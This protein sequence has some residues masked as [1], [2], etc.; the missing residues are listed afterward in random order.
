VRAVTLCDDPS[1]ST[2]TIVANRSTTAGHEH[3]DLAASPLRV[4]VIANRTAATPDLV[5]AVKRYADQRPTSF[6]L[7][8]PDA[9]RAEHPDWTLELA[10]SLLRRAARGRVTGLTGPHRDPCAAARNLLATN[11]FDRII[12]STLPDRAS[13]WRR[14]DL[15]RRLESLGVPVEVIGPARPRLSD[16][17]G[18]PM[19]SG[20]ELWLKTGAFTKPPAEGSRRQP[21]TAA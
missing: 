5:A 8:I 9:P 16:I 12:I 15:P 2:N 14:R 21:R 20:C 17:T 11:A 4:L 1:T 13:K 18:A 3:V 10:L 7:L 19:M 6:T